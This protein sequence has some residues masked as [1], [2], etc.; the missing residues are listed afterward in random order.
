MIKPSPLFSLVGQTRRS[1]S[2]TESS[3][4]LKD[5][6]SL[7]LMEL[8]FE[9]TCNTNLRGDFV[10]SQAA[11]PTEASTQGS[12]EYRANDSNPLSYDRARVEVE[13]APSNGKAHLILDFSYH[14]N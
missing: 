2:L 11:N 7:I 1:L 14:A 9:R 5:A 4:N 6:V 8:H 3:A 10:P 12:E 13:A